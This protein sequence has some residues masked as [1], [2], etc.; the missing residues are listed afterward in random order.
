ME[1]GDS[2]IMFLNVRPDLHCMR[3]ITVECPVHKFY[4]R[5]FPVNK[6]LQFLFHKL[7]IPEA[8]L[9]FH[10]GKT[11]TAGKRTATSRLIINDT[12]FKIA[13]LVIAEWNVT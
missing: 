5:H 10:R 1:I 13:R 12:V 2:V 7:R 9:L 6:K 4:L 8:K 3:M 11:V